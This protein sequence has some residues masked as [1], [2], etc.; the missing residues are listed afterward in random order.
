MTLVVLFLQ[1]IKP[2][3]LP[4]TQANGPACKTETASSAKVFATTVIAHPD[5]E[6]G[7]DGNVSGE[8]GEENAPNAA[9]YVAEPLLVKDTSPW[10]KAPTSKDGDNPPTSAHAASSEDCQ[11]DPDKGKSQGNTCLQFQK[12]MLKENFWPE[13]LSISIFHSLSLN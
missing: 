10:H 12:G 2:P 7:V 8:K 4:E 3:P 9:Q 11:H 6:K 5:D 1:G 13:K